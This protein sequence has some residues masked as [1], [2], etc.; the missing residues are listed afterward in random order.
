MLA[1]TSLPRQAADF[2]AVMRPP[3]ETGA[4]SYSC[5]AILTGRAA[6]HVTVMCEVLMKRLIASSIRDALKSSSRSQAA[7]RSAWVR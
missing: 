2:T 5:D 1:V 6:C 4:K 7:G 3:A